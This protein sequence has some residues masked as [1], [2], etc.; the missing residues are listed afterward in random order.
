MLHSAIDL[1]RARLIIDIIDASTQQLAWRGTGTGVL[2][3]NPT[4]EQITSNI[5]KA[6]SAIMSQYPPRK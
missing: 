3:D 4:A 5:N 6:V 1:S 2:D